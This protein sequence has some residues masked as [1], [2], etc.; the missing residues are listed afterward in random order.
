MKKYAL[1]LLPVA[2]IC[3]AGSLLVSGAVMLVTVLTAGDVANGLPMNYLEFLNLPTLSIMLPIIGMVF[4]I[5]SLPGI[6]AKR[7]AT[8]EAGVVEL[9]ARPATSSTQQSSEQHLKAA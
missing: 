8:R 9:T 7:E 6:L 1:F 5:F 4:L 2:A 3:V